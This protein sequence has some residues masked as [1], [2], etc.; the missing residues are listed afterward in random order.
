MTN[1]VSGIVRDTEGNALSG[2]Q[3]TILY[4]RP[5]VGA[6][7]G[8]AV[9]NT[10]IFT[11]NGAGLLTMANL[12]P[13]S[14][15]I[16]ISLPISS[17]SVPAIFLRS[18]SLVVLNQ[19]TQTLESAIVENVFPITPTLLQE[20]IA[21]RDAAE[22]AAIAAEAAVIGNGVR[23]TAN[24]T[25]GAALGLGRVFLLD[26][27]SYFNE[28]GGTA[29]D[30]IGVSNVSPYGT[31]T[32]DH[33]G[34]VGNFNGTS[35][36]NSTAMINRALT[37]WAAV[38]ARHLHFPSGW[39]YYAGTTSLDLG[40]RK[41][42]TITCDGQ[43]QFAGGTDLISWTITNHENADIQLRLRNG[44]T[45]GN[46]TNSLQVGGSTALQIHTTR[47]CRVDIEAMN[48]AGRVVHFTAGGTDATTRCRMIDATIKTG[49]RALSGD[50]A[51]C[52][53]P[54]FADSGTCDQTGAFGKVN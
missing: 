25:L 47:W 7:G 40:A 22:A 12:L 15:S 42:N 14:Y 3:V 6:D 31:G 35:G 23:N 48:Y 16:D 33:F 54:F 27:R 18:A 43:I 51:L 4:F 30:D 10:R 17:S 46:F 20:A 50:D 39:Y 36:T 41:W 8:A 26:G 1:T 2:L 49:N 38:S 9:A 37:W 52:G 44:G 19:A 28:T 53:Q 24:A 13:G 34:A 21:A 11:T 29:C 5:L 45:L 32:V